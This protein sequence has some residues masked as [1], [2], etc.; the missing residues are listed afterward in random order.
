MSICKI[1]VVLFRVFN[2]DFPL[3]LP[4]FLRHLKTLLFFLCELVFFVHDHVSDVG[5]I[6]ETFFEKIVGKST[7]LLRN[8][9]N[10]V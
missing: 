4:L 6:I 9:T 1:S 10:F 5:H 7:G 8:F 2:L 3:P